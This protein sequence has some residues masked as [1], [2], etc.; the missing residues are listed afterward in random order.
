MTIPR[1]PRPTTCTLLAVAVVVVILAVAVGC[2]KLAVAVT[3][4]GST[5]VRVV[6]DAEVSEPTRLDAGSANPELYED[7]YTEPFVF[8]RIDTAYDFRQPRTDLPI[9]RAIR[10]MHGDLG[11]DVSQFEIITGLG[12]THVLNCVFA[13]LDSSTQPTPPYTPSYSF[14]QQSPSYSLHENICKQLKIPWG[15][16][17]GKVGTIEVVTSPNNPTGELMRPRNVSTVPALIH[18]AVQEWPV[19]GKELRPG[20]QY[21]ELTRGGEVAVLAI[22]SFT[23][24]NGLASSRVGYALVSDHWLR[25]FPGFIDNYERV[26]RTFVLCGCMQGERIAATLAVK[27]QRREFAQVRS[28]LEARFDQMKDILEPAGFAILSKRGFP[29]VWVFKK[30]KVSDSPNSSDYFSNYVDLEIRDGKT[31]GASNEHVRLNI[32][33]KQSNWEKVVARIKARLE[34]KP[35]RLPAPTTARQILTGITTSSNPSN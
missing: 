19:Y 31:F 5:A 15:I 18:D 12:S 27:D 1:L 10:R 22:Y 8:E 16:G 32:Y 11:H 25:V 9:G 34:S 35:P 2:A 29:Y 26:M 33:Q 21:E 17:K 13:A 3:A 4:K 6:R 24:S 23:K 14:W 20:Q 30:G 28:I 7:I